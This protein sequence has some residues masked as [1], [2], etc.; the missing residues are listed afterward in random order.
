MKIALLLER[1]PFGEIVEKTLMRYLQ[2]RNGKGV[3]VRW[4]SRNLGAVALRRQG[5]QPWYCNPLADAIFSA[6]A[7]IKAR[8]EIRNRY[9]WSFSVWR[10][11][12]QMAYMSLA[13][14]P[15]LMG[16]MASQALGVAPPLDHSSKLLIRGGINR[17]RL[18]D[19]TTG[20]VAVLLKEGLSARLISDELDLRT[21]IQRFIPHVPK[22]LE[23]NIEQRFFVESILDGQV[24]GQL[25]DRS[26]QVCC[27]VKALSLL[28]AL[29]QG[30][31]QSISSEQFLANRLQHI[32]HYL[33]SY[34]LL[35][36]KM[37]RVLGKLTS[38]LREHLATYIAAGYDTVKT[39]VTHGDASDGNM[40]WDGEQVWW[41][42]WEFTS[43]RLWLYDYLVAGCGTRQQVGMG[44][45]LLR[46]VYKPNEVASYA[47]QAAHLWQ[48]PQEQEYRQFLV[49]FF[50]LEEIYYYLCVDDNP[51]ITVP[52]HA[53]CYIPAEIDI[54]LQGIET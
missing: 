34:S 12:A 15:P 33:D 40:I 2:Y 41:V 46:W 19:Y 49:L 1:E 38:K 37:R 25:G 36:N 8:H 32:R 45:K 50:L 5:Y 30:T 21:I 53:F 4:F 39:A 48:I 16:W 35:G 22:I 7:G 20:T 47:V 14:S 26:L 29:S 3:Q 6:N 23:T 42:D 27:M 31:M 11:T 18:F 10:R 52:N 28:A 17:L 43:R 54:V 44:G 9:S 13:T 24:V 51:I